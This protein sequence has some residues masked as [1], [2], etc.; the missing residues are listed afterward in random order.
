M[1]QR[2]LSYP[3]ATTNYLVPPPRD[4]VRP[5]V[6]SAMFTLWPRSRFALS[7]IDRAQYIPSLVPMTRW[8]TVN[9]RMQKGYRY[10]R[11]ARVGR[12]FDPEFTPDLTPPEMLRLGVFGGRYM[13]DGRG[14]FPKSWFT[15]AKLAKGRR[16]QR[17]RAQLLRRR[18]QSAAVGVE[19]EGL[20]TRG[21]P[22][23]VVPV[24]LP[25]LHGPANARRGQPADQ[26]LE[27]DPAA[28]AADRKE[29]R[30]RRHP[31]PAAAASGAAALGLR[32]PQDLNSSGPA[33]LTSPSGRG[34]KRH[35][36]PCFA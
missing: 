20:D 36:E 26:A 6:K 31:L 9:D 13:T 35:A 28:R 29:L 2:A 23:R 32:Q 8:V 24:V 12:D 21:R 27:D 11:T 1:P 16:G 25:L 30:E 33:Y 15:H 17:P 22:A 7:A 34:R 14:E 5:Q 19:E 18:R 3:V 4:D 10:A